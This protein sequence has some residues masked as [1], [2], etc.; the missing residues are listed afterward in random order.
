MGPAGLGEQARAG[1][2]AGHRQKLQGPPED[3]EQERRTLQDMLE[4]RTDVRDKERQAA[5]L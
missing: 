3:A 2:E 5:S 4:A 1:Q